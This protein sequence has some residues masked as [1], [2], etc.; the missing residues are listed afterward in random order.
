MPRQPTIAEIRLNDTLTCL[1]P[2]VSLLNDLHDA[3]GTPFVS[4]ISLT[5]L[6]LMA[7]VQ[8]S[9]CSNRSSC[10]VLYV[11]QNAKKNKAECTQLLESIL[12]VLHAILNLHIKSETAGSLPPAMLHEIGKF[13]VYVKLPSEQD[14]SCWV[15]RTLHK[16]HTFVEAQR[17]GNRIKSFFRQSEMSALLK[18]CREGL[19][20]AKEVFKASI[21]LS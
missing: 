10:R 11:M 14:C 16:T 8:A 20:R 13:T 1:K 7:S 2:A 9:N 21:L 15:H 12:Q 6:S 3:F 17:D 4:V 19:E 18:D 5:T